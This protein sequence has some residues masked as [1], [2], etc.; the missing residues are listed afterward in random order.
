MCGKSYSR[1]TKLKARAV[2]VV[3]TLGF[4]NKGIPKSVQSLHSGRLTHRCACAISATIDRLHVPLATG[5]LLEC[6]RATNAGCACGC[7]RSDSRRNAASIGAG[8]GAAAESWKRASGG[9]LDIA[10]HDACE[11]NAAVA[12]DARRTPLLL[13]L[14][15]LL[16]QGMRPPLPLADMPRRPLSLPLPPRQCRQ[17]PAK[18]EKARVCTSW[19][20][21]SVEE[22]CACSRAVLLAACAGADL[23]TRVPQ[24]LFLGFVTKRQHPRHLEEA[25]GGWASDLMPRRRGHE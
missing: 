22:P 18:D 13:A 24:T 6:R 25:V 11:L 15:K 5:P 10:P 3:A 2:T 21:A 1:E 9:Q 17:A 7:G 8:L 12:G 23:Q 19:A 14:P 20:L 4:C 16:I